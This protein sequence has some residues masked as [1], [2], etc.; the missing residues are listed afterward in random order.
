M[1]T[2]HQR[3]EE[4]RTWFQGKANVYIDYANVRAKCKKRNWTLDFAKIKKLYEETGNVVAV[5]VYFGKIVGHRPSEGF[6]AMIRKCGFEVIT[7]PV[8]HMR[9][10]IRCSSAPTPSSAGS[11]TSRLMSLR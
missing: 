11:M 2:R 5:K 8:K 7:K 9:I 1:L 4:L 10:S 3:I 6:I